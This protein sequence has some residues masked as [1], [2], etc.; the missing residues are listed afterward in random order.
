MIRWIIKANGSRLDLSRGGKEIDRDFYSPD[1][2]RREQEEEE[3]EGG[4][5]SAPVD[6]LR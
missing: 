3:E 5:V 4:G 6:C 2:R 1:I